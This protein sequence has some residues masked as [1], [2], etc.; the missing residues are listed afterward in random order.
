MRRHADPDPHY[1]D[2]AERQAH[3]TELR[4]DLTAIFAGAAPASGSTC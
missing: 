1:A 2:P 4:E 3:A